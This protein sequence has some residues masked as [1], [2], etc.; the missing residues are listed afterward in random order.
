MQERVRWKQQASQ[1][2]EALKPAL[3]LEL[4]DSNQGSSSTALTPREARYDACRKE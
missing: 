3:Q 1:K 2:S 4:V